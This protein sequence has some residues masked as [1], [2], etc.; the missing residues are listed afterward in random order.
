VTELP[1][2]PG[3]IEEYAAPEAYDERYRSKTD[4]V[5]FYVRLARGAGRVLE[6]G[7]GT[8]R[9]TLPMARAGA[10]VTALDY[11]KPMLSALERKLEGEPKNV[12][13]NVT[14]CHSDMRTMR[15]GKT[16]PLIVLAFDTFAHL[17]SRM[18][19]EAFLARA[20]AHLEPEGS[21]VFDVA[22][23]EMPEAT[24]GVNDDGSS[25]DY[26]SLSQVLAVQNEGVGADGFLAARRLFFP[27]E[28]PMLLEENGFARVRVTLVSPN[29]GPRRLRV[30]CRLA[31][32]RQGK[33]A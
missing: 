12:Q 2:H 15:V 8:G 23:P 17:Y 20:R 33:G 26:D 9:V 14:V 6:C 21:L 30:S 24:T 7:A 10:R 18:D 5:A 29:G 25:W 28:L 31:A 16:F 32:S 3:A 1:V 13:K 4:D 11:S 22:M 27:R 19:V